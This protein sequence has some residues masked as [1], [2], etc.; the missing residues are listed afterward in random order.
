MTTHLFLFT[1]GPVQGFI[2]QA[3]KTRDL[4]AGS[5]ILSE[6]VAKGMQTFTKEFP[7]GK[8]IFPESGGE[9]LPNRFVGKVTANESELRPKALAI[10]KAVEETWMEIAKSSLKKAGIESKPI[11]FD[12][13]IKALLEIH[14]VFNEIKSDYV[15]AYREL[16]RLGGA[17]KN[18]RRFVQLAEVGRKCS[19]DGMNNAMFYQKGSNQPQFMN[20]PEPVSGFAISPGEGLSAVSLTKRFY[21]VDKAFPST[22][23][24]ALMRDIQKL[25][26]DN[27][28]RLQC[29]ENLFK[30]EKI[31]ET[32]L[33]M[34]DNGFI[35]KYNIINPKEFDNWNEEWDEHFLYEDNLEQIV[36]PTQKDLLGNLHKALKKNLK[37]RYYAVIMFDGDHMG[38]WL[39]GEF[40]LTKDDLE[41]F[42][43]KIS[44]A[45]ANFGKKARDYLNSNEGV[46]HTV[47]SGGDDFL[48]F[49]N[50]HHLFDVMKHLRWMF[51]EMVNKVIEPFRQ[52]GK[53]L[54]FSAGIVIAHYKMP[55][56]EVLKKAR[57]VEKAAKNEGE[58]NAF[59][60]AVMKHSGEIQQ[61]VYKWDT[62]ENKSSDCS[63]WE[64]L[65]RIYNALDKDDGQFS[66]TFI[67]NLTTEIQGL[68]GVDMQNLPAGSMGKTLNAAMRLEIQRLVDRA[69]KEGRKKDKDMVN[70]LTD[71]VINL[72]EESPKESGYRPRNFIHALHVV[73]F[74]TS[75]ITQES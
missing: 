19:I 36:N 21:K 25:S 33:K 51:D 66:N 65:E 24:V 69:W 49:V 50:I 28:E 22:S 29:F 20:Q 61:T 34:F 18:I 63:Y 58:R 39:S 59:G 48:G 52:T 67:Q 42:H 62:N 72:W 32:C 16:E 54:T 5:Q 2:A 40:N 53:Q 57:E 46:G 12:A 15:E 9:S 8:I 4:Y 74:L 55:F 70:A 41:D 60:I 7:S 11:G 14:W 38:R 1:I 31:A 43:L 35:E 37:T 27:Q 44:K 23:K 17:V 6:L 30:K 45:L 68:A 47:Y 64:A 3:R 56:S 10:Q 13:Q 73:D 26:P 75:K 71:I